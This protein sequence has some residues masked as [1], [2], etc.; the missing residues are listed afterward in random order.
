MECRGAECERGGNRVVD[1]NETLKL[2]RGLEALHD[3]LPSSDRLIRVL[4][5][6]VQGLVRLDAG[7]D[8]PLRRTVGSKLV[9]DHD[10]W[11]TALPFRSFP[12]NRLAALALRRLCTSTSRTKPS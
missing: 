2:S 8:L 6:I 1:G 12:I 3:P 7:H 11:R 10:T 5:P 9:G 4:R